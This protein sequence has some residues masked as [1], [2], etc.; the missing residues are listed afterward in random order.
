MIR[1]ALGL[2]FLVVSVPAMASTTTANVNCR[3]APDQTSVSVKRIPARTTVQVSGRANGWSLLANGDCWVLSRYITDEQMTQTQPRETYSQRAYVATPERASRTPAVRTP[4]Y[5]SST[6]ARPRRAIVGGQ[7]AWRKPAR[8]SRSSGGYSTGSSNC[9][10]S[11]G[12]IC[13][14]PR[15][16]RYCI[17]SGGN[18]RYGV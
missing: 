13:I 6:N 8:R 7:S 4:R 5:R 3:K 18:K 2:L 10:C 11:S 15:G 12:N 9:P 1:I 16:G 14:G 17:T